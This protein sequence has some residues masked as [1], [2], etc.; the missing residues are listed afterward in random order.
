MKKMAGQ[1]LNTLKRHETALCCI[2]LRLQF[3]YSNLQIYCLVQTLNNIVNVQQNLQ[4][5]V[6]NMCSC[7]FV[8]CEHIIEYNNEC[9]PLHSDPP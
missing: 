3:I 4:K 5:C 2:W 6:S 9:L 8:Q 1:F 7:D